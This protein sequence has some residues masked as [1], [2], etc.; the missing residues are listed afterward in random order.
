LQLFLENGYDDLEIVSTLEINQL[1]ETFPGIVPGHRGKIWV[2]I[3]KLKN[4][5]S[6]NVQPSIIPKITSP[7][8]R[9]NRHEPSTARIAPGKRF[10][11]LVPD[12]P[13][14]KESVVNCLQKFANTKNLDIGTV[15]DFLARI[16]DLSEENSPKKAFALSLC[17][18]YTTESWVYMTVNGLLRDDSP[19]IE[20]LA[21]FMNALMRSYK[22]M[23]GDEGN[24][25]TG[26]TYRRTRLTPKF[27][28]FYQPDV[29]FVWSAFTSTA[30]E[31]TTDEKF[32]DVLFI[33]SVPEKFKIYALNLENISVFP[34]EREVLL[35]PN[36]G[37]QVAS[38]EKGPTDAFPNISTII[39]I[40]VAYVCVS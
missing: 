12:A 29:Q 38:I 40:V 3:Q 9:Q 27:L 11:N 17:W 26:I 8:P 16:E 7:Q 5:H 4:Q 35:L 20:T 37:F 21:P 34:T 14:D 25:Y 33:I 23:E 22:E 32:G 24:F 6:S 18:L 28:Q 1:E 2:A 15:Q 39:K 13:T 31:F 19:Q 30:I 36:I 10:L